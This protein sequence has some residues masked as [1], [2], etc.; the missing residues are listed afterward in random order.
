MYHF[1]TLACQIPTRL[2]NGLVW[3][4]VSQVDPHQQECMEHLNYF[5]QRQQGKLISIDYNFY[6]IYQD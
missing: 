5:V 4:E 1:P 6:W 2:S 3:F